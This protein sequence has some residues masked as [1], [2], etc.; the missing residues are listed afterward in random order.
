MLQIQGFNSRVLYSDYCI[1]CLQNPSKI[2]VE[3]SA[4]LTQK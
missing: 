2:G 1:V 3:N 4:N